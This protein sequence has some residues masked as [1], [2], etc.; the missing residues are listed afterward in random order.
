VFFTRIIP[1]ATSRPQI[2]S[3]FTVLYPR[4]SW[5]SILS[6][7]QAK[8]ALLVQF[9]WIR[10]CLVLGLPV[11]LLQYAV[12]SPVFYHFQSIYVRSMHFCPTTVTTCTDCSTSSPLH[13]VQFHANT[14]KA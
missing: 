13:T 10:W 5:P 7:F 2:F 11:T 9:R 4:S 3:N 12:S 6:H 14:K 1:K 8:G